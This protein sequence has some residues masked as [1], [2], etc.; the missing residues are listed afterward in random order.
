MSDYKANIKEIENQITDH[1]HDQY[2]TTPEFN[3]LTSETFAARLKQA[4][5]MTK[6]EFDSKLRSFNKQIT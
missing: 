2:S 3:K 1:N 6:T 4:N 5:W